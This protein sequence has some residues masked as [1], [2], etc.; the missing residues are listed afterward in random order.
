MTVT[1]SFADEKI[2]ND[3]DR[4]WEKAV[5]DEIWVDEVIFHIIRVQSEICRVNPRQ[6]LI[7]FVLIFQIF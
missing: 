2:E 5:D 4:K 3:Q 6:R 1:Y 7:V